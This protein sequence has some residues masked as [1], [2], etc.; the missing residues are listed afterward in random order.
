MAVWAAK[1]VLAGQGDSLQKGG[2]RAG[3][4]FKGACYGRSR[5]DYMKQLCVVESGNTS[6]EVQ[7]IL[8]HAPA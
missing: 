8:R 3:Q 2:K 7:D 6:G 1:Q 4:S 5:Y